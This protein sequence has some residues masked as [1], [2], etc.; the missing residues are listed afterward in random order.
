MFGHDWN[1]R[2]ELNTCRR[3]KHL[4]NLFC[5]YLCYFRFI[6]KLES[7]SLREK[8]IV[9]M[10]GKI[11]L[12]WNVNL[13]KPCNTYKQW[14]G[15]NILNVN[16]FNCWLP[17]YFETQTFRKWVKFSTFVIE[18]L[19]VT[20]RLQQVRASAGRKLPTQQRINTVA[21]QRAPHL[22]LCSIWGMS[23]FSGVSKSP[24]R[25]SLRSFEKEFSVTW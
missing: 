25:V 10:R 21:V 15:K 14:N 3:V 2:T 23:T 18:N 22:T 24:W 8:T 13:L 4:E 12:E 7:Q 20:N 16:D 17:M 11:E 6:L 19:N 9:D 1:K 5:F